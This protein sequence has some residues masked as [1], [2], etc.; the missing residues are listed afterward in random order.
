MMLLFTKVFRII[1]LLLVLII[2][3][4]CK[5][6]KPVSSIYNPPFGPNAPEDAYFHGDEYAY[7]GTDS[8]WN[9]RF[10]YGYFDDWYK[11]IGQ[12]MMLDLMDNKVGETEKYAREILLNRYPNDLEALFNL[13]VSLAHQNRINEALQI[14]RQSVELGL[15]FGRYLAGPRDILKPLTESDLFKEYASNFHIPLI[16]GP[17][18]GGVTDNSAS[19]WVRTPNEVKVQVRVSRSASIIEVIDSEI[20]ITDPD[21]DFTTIVTVE[22][23]EANTRYYYEVII[24]GE[25]VKDLGELSFHTYPPRGSNADFKIA[26]GGG[27][28]FVPPNERI[29][30]VIKQKQPLA[31]LAMGD[32]IY[33]SQH[34]H[35]YHPRALHNYTY[36]RRQSREEFQAFT[37]ST[38]IYAIWDDHE[39]TDDVWLGPFK[40]KP[41]WKLTLFEVF[42]NNWVNPSYGTQE[43]P[44]CWHRFSIGDVDIFMLDGRF[45]RTNPYAKEPTKSNNYAEYPTMLGPVQK[46]WLLEGLKNSQATFKIIASPVPWAYEAKPDSKDTWN[47][48]REER[49]EIFNFLAEHKIEGVVLLA[50]DRH[51]SDAW[52]IERPNGYPLYEFMC[53]RITNEHKHPLKP[54]ALFGYNEKQSFGLLNFETTKS[55]PTLTYEIFSIDDEKVY[56]LTLK[57][58]DLN[59]Q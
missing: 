16:H 42:R 51:R 5:N 40:H 8:P 54:E 10:F 44:G 28:G 53:S 31:F 34:A 22:N 47:G 29:W 6:D 14:V 46:E 32:N 58:S 12:R 49:T 35:P 33:V 45:Y 39:F 50:A 25:S 20:K 55:D 17:M 13:A 23:L 41:L 7:Y 15:P 9:Q 11:R 26:F 18:V 43:W 24:N 2:V 48:F 21:K 36:Y 56:S 52:K 3:N 57:L 4:S 37:S 1:F 27:S 19:F 38:S 30:N 59:H